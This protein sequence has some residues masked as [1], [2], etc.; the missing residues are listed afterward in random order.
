M[1]CCKF[2]IPTLLIFLSEKNLYKFSVALQ[3]LLATS[4]HSF[5]KSTSNFRSPQSFRLDTGGL[6]YKP[7]KTTPHYLTSPQNFFETNERIK[8][9]MGKSLPNERPKSPYPER[10]KEII[11]FIETRLK[12]RLLI[13]GQESAALYEIVMK[14]KNEMISSSFEV[15]LSNKDEE[16]FIDTVKRVLAKIRA[17]LEEKQQKLSESKEQYRDNGQAAATLNSKGSYFVK[18]LTTSVKSIEKRIEPNETPKEQTKAAAVHRNENNVEKPAEKK[19]AKPPINQKVV[20]PQTKPEP[21]RQKAPVQQP[22]N[23][24]S[25]SGKPPS[26]AKTNM[27]DLIFKTFF[28]ETEEDFEPL[29]IGF[30]KHLYE[31][32]DADLINVLNTCETIPK[33]VVLI[34]ELAMKAYNKFFDENFQPSQK[35]YILKNRNERASEICSILH[36]KII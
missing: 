21:Q 11:Q 12:D 26:N 28:E 34:K 35:E 4:K 9:P 14:E 25:T 33:A 27:L 16:D 36:V 18:P 13:T 3:D 5:S 19:A 23:N 31:N 15:F 7:N 17:G 30:A 24:N 2:P 1:L 8:T 22:V 32:S 6:D 29:E 20:Q 10:S